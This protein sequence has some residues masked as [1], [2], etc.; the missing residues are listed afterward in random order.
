MQVRGM[1]DVQLAGDQL[2]PT[3]PKGVGEGGVVEKAPT[4]GGERDYVPGRHEQCRAGQEE[5]EILDVLARSRQLRRELRQQLDAFAGRRCEVVR[6][7]R[8]PSGTSSSRRTATRAA[9]L[10]E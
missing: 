8:E 1:R 3:C 5:A 7:I 2:E 9:S 4:D 10:R 6:I